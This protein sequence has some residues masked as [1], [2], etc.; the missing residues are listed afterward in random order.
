[1]GMDVRG[2]RGKRRQAKRGLGTLIFR[3]PKRRE[4]GRVRGVREK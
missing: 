2:E 1:M 3:A 4:R